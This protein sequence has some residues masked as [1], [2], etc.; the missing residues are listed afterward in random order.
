MSMKATSIDVPSRSRSAIEELYRLHSAQALRLAYVLTGNPT[1]AEDIAQEAIVRVIARF[2]QLQ[3]P[4]RVRGYLNRVVINLARNRA[5][6][7]IRKRK[8]LARLD[9]A[10]RTPREEER[11]TRVH[12]EGTW[13]ALLLL[14]PRQ[15][16]ALY[17]RYYEDL[18]EI[19]AARLL[20]CTPGA[21]KSLINRALD[22]LRKEQV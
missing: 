11:V 6:G 13:A 12:E 21:L 5:R 20:D 18:T 1:D 15:R 17:F 4:D 19:E 8:A 22:T 2:G 10:R 7:S 16:A 14:P 3:S 9:G